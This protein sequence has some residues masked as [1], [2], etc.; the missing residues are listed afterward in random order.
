MLLYNNLLL[1]DIA[2]KMLKPHIPRSMYRNL[3]DKDVVIVINAEEAIKG[4]INNKY[5][6]LLVYNFWSILSGLLSDTNTPFTSIGGASPIA[7]TFIKVS[8]GA[9]YVVFGVDTVA[10][11]F[12]QFKL[13]NRVTALEGTAISPTIVRESDRIRVRFGRVTADTVYEVGLYQTIYDTGG[14]AHTVMHG[15]KVIPNTPGGRQ[16]FYDIVL[17]SPFTAQMA[18]YVFGF[19]TETNQS[20][21]DASGGSYTARTGGDV[22]AGGLYLAIG[23]GSGA[24]TF[25]DINLTSR[26]DLASAANNI[27]S[28]PT[29]SLLIVSGAIRLSSAINIAEIGLL[30]N[31]FDTAAGTH[32]TLLARIVLPTAV[33]K[34]AGDAFT[35]VISILAGA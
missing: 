2:I 4:I 5:K 33:P 26:I 1:N 35:A 17:F 24:F 31:I 7:R 11:S 27:Q 18:R 3:Y 20:M 15:R 8:G 21:T 12:T 28:P 16:V 13:G 10:E 32:P 25:D 14:Y 34:A 23:T 30:Q 29:R 22:N 9:A 6:N 19:L